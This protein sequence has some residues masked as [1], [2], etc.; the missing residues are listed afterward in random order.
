MFP[1]D[2]CITYAKCKTQWP[3]GN[4]DLCLSF[5]AA[6]MKDKSM[7]IAGCSVEHADFPENPKITRVHT[8]MTGYRLIPTNNGKGSKLIYITEVNLMFF[9]C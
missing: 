6:K 5:N 9:K 2:S 8:T 4:R 3:L 7:Y 1:M